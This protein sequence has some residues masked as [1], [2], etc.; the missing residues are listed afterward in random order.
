MDIV[1]LL[2]DSRAVPIIAAPFIIALCCI[3]QL[4]AQEDF[5]LFFTFLFPA[6]LVAMLPALIAKLPNTR[7][8]NLDTMLIACVVLFECAIIRSAL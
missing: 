5:I 7:K 3:T 2:R 8:V 4:C 6:S 1:K